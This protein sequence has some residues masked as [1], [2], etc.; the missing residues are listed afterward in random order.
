MID[1]TIIPNPQSS[2]SEFPKFRMFPC[3]SQGGGR[4]HPRARSLEPGAHLTE[5][6]LRVGSQGLQS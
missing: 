4:E 1:T 2:L 5:G 3:D 6:W